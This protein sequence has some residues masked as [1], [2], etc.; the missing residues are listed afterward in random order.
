MKHSIKIV[1]ELPIDKV[2]QIL[3][4][5]QNLTHWQ[6]GLQ[7]F[8][9]LSGNPSAV[10]GKMKLNYTLG[11][12]NIVL[13]KTT[14]KRELPNKLDFQFDMKGLHFIQKNSFKSTED[15]HTEWLIE[16]KFVPTNFFTQ[17]M[18]IFSPGEFKNQIYQYMIDFKNFA[19]KGISVKGNEKELLNTN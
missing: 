1:L 4:N 17:M 12:K 11:N 14:T 10:G 2:V 5:N 6:R 19:E 9:H 16:N 8:E 7:S 18:L 3:D 13:T 15:N